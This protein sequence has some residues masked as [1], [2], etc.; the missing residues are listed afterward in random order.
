[1]K[2]SLF[3]IVLLVIVAA[4]VLCPDAAYAAP[5]GKIVSGLFKTPVGRVILAILVVIL[6][7]VIA[8]VM[9]KEKIA[10]LL[11]NEYSLYINELNIF[12]LEVEL[13]NFRRNAGIEISNL[14][15]KIAKI[16][17]WKPIGAILPSHGCSFPTVSDSSL[18]RRKRTS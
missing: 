5:G 11:S 4:I 2:R 16:L 8:Y 9:I 15:H 13:A 12:T 1:M 14:H 10:E 17:D 3:W 18:S 6:S 7:P